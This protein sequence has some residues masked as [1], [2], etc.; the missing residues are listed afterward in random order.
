MKIGVLGGT[1]PLGQGLAVRFADRGHDVVLGSRDAAKSEVIVSELQEQWGSRLDT[2]TPGANADAAATDMVVLATVWD[3]AVATA[4]DLADQL[5]GRIVICVANGLTK[6]GKQ[7]SPVLPPEGS[8][9]AAVQAAAPGARVIAAFQHIPAAA[10]RDLD[11]ELE[12]DVLVAGDDD[13]AR[14]LVI[15][16]VD[17]LGTLRGLDVGGLV[18][19]QGIETFAAAMLTVNL[20]YKGESTLHLGGV[21]AHK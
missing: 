21:G 6:V 12:G 1:G 13:D 10:L 20:R 7:F 14:N 2:L 15:D 4:T 16:L 18:N 17:D 8:I 3:A 11:G 19:A 9:A 5:D